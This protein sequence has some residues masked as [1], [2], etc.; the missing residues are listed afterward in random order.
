MP[1]AKQW[2]DP[3]TVHGEG[4]IWNS[5]IQRFQLV[6]MLEGDILTVHEGQLTDRVHI[7]AVAAVI[8]P[9]LHGGLVV[10]GERDVVLIDPAGHQRRVGDTGIPVGARFNDGACARDGSFWCGTMSYDAAPGAGRMLRLDPGTLTFTEVMTDLT[11]SNGLA[12]TDVDSA[13]YVDSPTRRIDRLLVRDGTITSRTPWVDLSDVDGV[14]DGICIDADDGVWVALFGGGAVRRY[15]RD[16]T[17]TDIIDV[18]VAQVTACTLGGVDRREL[19]ITTS[20][21]GLENTAGPDGALFRAVVD[22]PGPFTVC[23]GG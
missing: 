16:G 2:T 15:D 5:L 7:D 12:F 20:R 23:F 3:I 11:V 8:R 17:L 13:F 6:D 10:A 9:R 4:P 14:P 1:D 22:V 19:I 18:P 21:L